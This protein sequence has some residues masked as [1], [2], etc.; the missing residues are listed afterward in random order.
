MNRGNQGPPQTPTRGKWGPNGWAPGDTRSGRRGPP[1]D[2]AAGRPAAGLPARCHSN[3]RSALARPLAHSRGGRPAPRRQ[4]PLTWAGGRAGFRLAL[5]L[6][7]GGRRVRNSA[8]V[9][10][11]RPAGQRQGG[12]RGPRGDKARSLERSPSPCGRVGEEGAPRCARRRPGEQFL[13]GMDLR[14][15]LGDTETETCYTKFK[16]CNSDITVLR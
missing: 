9:E 3:G 12:G 13:L 4:Q 10:T 7:A 14:N 6:R 8:T 2:P 11:F 16:L 5:T 15:H 1:A